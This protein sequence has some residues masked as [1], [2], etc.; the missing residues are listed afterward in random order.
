MSKET[1]TSEAMPSVSRSSQGL[2]D[3]M[4]DELDAIRNGRS[5]PN[6]LIAVSKIACQIINSVKM[7]IEYQKHVASSAQVSERN[8]FINGSNLQLGAP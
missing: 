5:N 7:E 6:R 4:F 3:L 1:A 8:E 2:R